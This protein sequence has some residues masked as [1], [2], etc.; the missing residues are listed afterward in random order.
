MTSAAPIM[1]PPKQ[2]MREMHNMN[3]SF[4][5]PTRQQ[6]FKTGSDNRGVKSGRVG[7]G[8]LM[9]KTNMSQPAK[10]KKMGRIAQG[11][12]EMKSCG[13]KRGRRKR[14]RRKS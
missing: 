13:F 1:D 11:Q 4:A 5:K 12:K 8:R 14:R 3:G 10:W 9:A 7:K 2:G 6:P